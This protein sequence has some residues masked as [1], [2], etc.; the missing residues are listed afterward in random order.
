MFPLLVV[1]S[2][3]RRDA[4]SL[5]SRKVMCALQINIDARNCSWKDASELEFLS[6]Q[7]GT[8]VS[9]A[10]QSHQADEY[11]LGDQNSFSLQV[12]KN[13]VRSAT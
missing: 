8:R 10:R 5:H 11:D 12:L 13:T 9:S 7:N 3:S 6:F 1:I 2:I 4:N